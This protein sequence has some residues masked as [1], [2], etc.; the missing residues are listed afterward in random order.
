MAG[1]AQAAQVRKVVAAAV[2]ERQDVVDFLNWGGHSFF[3]AVFAQRM[4]RDVSSANLAPACTIAAVDL[5]VTLK[6]T[7]VLI[8]LFGV[9]LAEPFAGQ[10]GT[11]RLRAGTFGF[12]W[13]SRYLLW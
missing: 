1:F 10:F 8:C 2:L 3:Q 12:A 9:E 6:L 5:R 7:I 4:L 11:A 13:H